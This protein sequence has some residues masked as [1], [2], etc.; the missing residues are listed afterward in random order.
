MLTFKITNCAD[1]KLIPFMFAGFFTILTLALFPCM[2]AHILAKEAFAFIPDMFAYLV[3][4]F[5]YAVFI[6]MDTNFT[7]HC[8]VTVSPS[9]MVTLEA[10]HLTSATQPCMST[11]LVTD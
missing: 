10:A 11:V 9:R 1:T 2:L 8:T 6:L 7:A 3:T 4:Q 5:T